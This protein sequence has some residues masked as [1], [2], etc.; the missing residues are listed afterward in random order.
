MGVFIPERFA[1]LVEKEG[2]P[3]P[4]ARVLNKVSW[5][6]ELRVHPSS[7]TSWLREGREPGW[8]VVRHIAEV[9]GVSEAWLTGDSDNPNRAMQSEGAEET[10]WRRIAYENAGA[11][12]LANRVMLLME[13]DLGLGPLGTPSVQKPDFE[14]AANVGY[15]VSRF[16]AIHDVGPLTP[17]RLARMLSERYPRKVT[18]EEVKEIL[19]GVV[20]ERPLLAAFA[21][22]LGV[23]PGWLLF[24]EDTRAPMQWK[25]RTSK[26]STSASPQMQVTP[27]D[28]AQKPVKAR[29]IKKNSA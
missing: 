29:D 10:T 23:D 13:E 19:R 25:P 12:R 18:E 21:H 16:Q 28:E 27:L 24:D 6:R 4:E 8:S 14:F 7:V 15:A 17:D 1:R 3:L 5:A 22:M 11:R 26:K 9:A 20:P 2:D